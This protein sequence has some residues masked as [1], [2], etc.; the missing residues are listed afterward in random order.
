[1]IHFRALLERIKDDEVRFKLERKLEDFILAK[2]RG[3]MEIKA[4]YDLKKD[5]VS[6]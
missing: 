4:I 3:D 6:I 2:V 5:V 1:M